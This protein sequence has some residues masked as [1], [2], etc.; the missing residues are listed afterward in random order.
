MF[1]HEI[2][3]VPE[4]TVPT[5][6]VVLV[7][8]AALVIANLVALLPGFAASRTRTVSLLRAE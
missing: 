8:V 7:A 2:S 5:V 3:A 1:A 4:P 6:Q